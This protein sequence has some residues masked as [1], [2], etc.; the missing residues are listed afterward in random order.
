MKSKVVKISALLLALLMLVGAV[1]CSGTKTMMTLEK[2][3]ISLNLYQLMLSIQ[4]GNMA[5][6]IKYWY[7]DVDSDDFW[8]TVIDEKST[9]WDDYYTLAVYKKAKNLLAAATLFREME[10]TLSDA[11]VEEI[12]EDIEELIKTEGSK[13]ALNAALAQYG[14]NVELYREYKLLEAKSTAVA[15]ELYGKNGSKIG[16]ALK[17]NYFNENYVAF[18]QILISNFYYVYKTDK[19]GD[20]IYYMGTGA[21]A[22][23]TERGTPVMEDGKLVYYDEEGRIAYDTDIGK[24]SPVLDENGDHKM[25]MY[26]EAEMDAR[27]DKAIEIYDMLGEDPR[28]FETAREQYSDERDIDGTLEEG[29][30]YLATNADYS[31]INQG[32][33][34]DIAD[35]AEQLAVGEVAL[36]SSEY[37]YHIIR[38]YALEQGAYAGEEQEK[39]FTDSRYGVYDFIANLENDLFLAVLEP[40]TER[41][42][43]DSELLDSV[44]L[45]STP[46][47]YNYH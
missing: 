28:V 9:T 5:Y 27:A 8:S 18:Q 30:C 10:L 43:T 4:K 1:G 39:W 29:L 34:D 6:L 33:M 3:S 16:A 37:G 19:N 32:F 26:T 23:D 15:E 35:A 40:Y 41:I 17:E 2:E 25:E 38:R 42:A 24:P 46:A 12:D 20:V 13:K 22:Y 44:S 14:V 36:V 47:N 21:I 45:K 7:G 11:V 31:S